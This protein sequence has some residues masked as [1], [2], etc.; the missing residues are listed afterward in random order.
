MKYKLLQRF[1]H[2]FC[3]LS[4]N[5]RNKKYSKRGRKRFFNEQ[6]YKRRFV[7]ERAFAWI[8]SFKTLLVR[9]DK[10]DGLALFRMRSYFAKSLNV[11]NEKTPSS[12]L[13]KG[14]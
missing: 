10:L 13:K 7:N 9:F 11:F 2:P 6:I 3:V 12:F 5:I 1:H 4:Q 8:D 14:L